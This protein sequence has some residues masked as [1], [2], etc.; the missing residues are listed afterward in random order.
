MSVKIESKIA[1]NINKFADSKLIKKRKK[2]P[3]GSAYKP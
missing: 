3:E 2:E 1:K